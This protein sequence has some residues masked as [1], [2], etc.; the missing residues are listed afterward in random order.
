MDGNGRW[1]ELRGSPR[2]EGHRAGVIS[3]RKV[4]NA[5]VDKQIPILSLFAFSS[6]NWNRPPEEVSF[7][8]QL[9]V[10][11]IE[12]EIDELYENGVWLRFIGNREH[13]PEIVRLSLES[14]DKIQ[15][16]NPKLTMNIVIN[17]GGRWDIVEAAKTLASQVKNNEIA[18]S[19]I[20]EALFAKTL[21]TKMLPDPDLLIRTSGEIRI[22]NFFLWQL[23]YSE[24]YF[25]E[26]LWPDFDTDAFEKA[27]SYFSSRIRR[28]GKTSQQ[29]DIHHV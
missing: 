10:E 21:S 17:Y 20:D 15:M 27:L 19:S 6:E 26:T 11:S 2:V 7:L 3:I 13:L 24:L 14:V 29:C 12:K 9:F 4:V 1:A 28:F 18:V 5:C 8:M 23:A 22:S 16:P 25:C